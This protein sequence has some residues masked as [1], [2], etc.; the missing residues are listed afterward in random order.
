MIKIIASQPASQPASQ[1]SA[2]AR[3]INWRHSLADP[4]IQSMLALWRH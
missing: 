3:F 2:I 4:I 1:E